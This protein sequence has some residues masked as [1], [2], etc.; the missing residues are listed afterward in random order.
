MQRDILE[1]EWVARVSQTNTLHVIE[2]DFLTDRHPRVHTRVELLRVLQILEHDFAALQCLFAKARLERLEVFGLLGEHR[3]S[4]RVKT[5]RTGLSALL[6]PERNH[7]LR[8][9]AE[10]AG[11]A[12]P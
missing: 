4:G 12:T 3:V 11:L 10:R 6:S 1:G 8:G 5:A 2:G 9:A 7:G